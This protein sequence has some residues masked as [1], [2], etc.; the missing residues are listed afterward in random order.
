MYDLVLR[1]KQASG[2]V[3]IDPI[4]APQLVAGE[5]VDPSGCDFENGEELFSRD[6]GKVWIGITLIEKNG[7]LQTVEVCSAVW[8]TPQVPPDFPACRG[9]Q[10]GVEL[11]LNVLRYLTAQCSMFVDSLHGQTWCQ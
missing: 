8:T 10:P 9:M 4:N 3:D 1:S 7:F 5:G 11:N 2:A 6:R